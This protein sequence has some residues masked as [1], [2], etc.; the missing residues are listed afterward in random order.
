MSFSFL[1]DTINNAD[2]NRGFYFPKEQKLFEDF[3]YKADICTSQWGARVRIR[4]E[5]RSI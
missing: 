2:S 3:I 5:G 4:K 1:S